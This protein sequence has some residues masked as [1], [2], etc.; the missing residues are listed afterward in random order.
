MDHV[1][2]HCSKLTNVFQVANG[3]VFMVTIFLS[4]YA[5][6]SVWVTS[7]AYSSPSI[8]LSAR[9]GDGGRV[10]FDDFRE[11]YYWLRHNTAEVG[12]LLRRIG[13]N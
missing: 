10:I 11:A 1:E 3:V 8:V 4:M 5:L 12:V 6:H 13:K 2:L 9:G 7:E